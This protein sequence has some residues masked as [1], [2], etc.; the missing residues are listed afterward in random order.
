MKNLLVI[1]TLAIA[2]CLGVMAN[3]AKAQNDADPAITSMSFATSPILIGNSTTLTVFFLNNGFT[4]AI[5]AGSVGLNISLPTSGEYVA[6]PLSTAAVSGTFAGKF[7]WTYNTVTNNFFGVSNQAIA[8][9]D[10]GT[11]VVTV[12]GVISTQ[13]T[14]SV[15]NIQRINPS[16]YPNE[17]IN[18]NN[19][20]AFLAVIPG[21]PLPIS[22]LN[23][24]A[25]KQNNVVNLNWQTSTEAN[26]KHFDV[27]FS[28]NG[29]NWQSIGIV[30][31]AGN[32]SSTQSYAFV[33]THPV[34]GVNYYWLKSVDINNGFDYSSTRTVNFNKKNAI[35][36]MPNPTVDRFSITSNG[37]GSLQS[38]TIF[39]ADGRIIQSTSNFVL[40][41]SIDMS[42][43]GPGIYT[44]RMMDKSGDVEVMKV[45][46][47]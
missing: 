12:K 20:T 36:I 1:K 8:A 37:G 18:N 4:T 7:N 10:G 31:A 3:I 28:K 33:H 14:I 9:G 45:I 21:G 44:V 29:V 26:S 6:N 34:K 27:Q 47:Q 2:L 16:Q 35:V 30:T 32:S 5:T 40:G 38:V 15:A 19:L 39:S 22:L 13:Q 24:T 41:N 17:N 46:K 23:F 11:I 43:F 25:T 42:R